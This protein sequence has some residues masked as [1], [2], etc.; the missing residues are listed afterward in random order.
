MAGK[1]F[2]LSVLFEVID[3]AS[4]PIQKI[5]RTLNTLIRP[6]TRVVTAFTGLA[7]K[8][9]KVMVAVGKN[10]ANV[11]RGLKKIGTRITDIGKSLALRVT[12]P[13]LALGGI[14]LNSAIKFESAFA[15]VRKTVNASEEELQKLK[16]GLLGLA[17]E[18]P[19]DTTEFFRIGEAAGQLGIQTKNIVAFSKVMAT[20]GATTNLSAEEAATALARFANITQLPQDQFDRIAS[21]I[22]EL[23][24]N[25]ATTEREIVD[26]AL[27]LASAADL[28]GLSEAETLS[29]AAALS[30]LGLQAQRG[31]TAF[32]KVFK[33]M[34]KEI[35]T[36]SKVLSGFAKVSGKTVSGFEESFRKNA[37]QAVLDFVEGLSRLEKEGENVNQVLEIL[38]FQD[39]RVADALLRAAG[40]GEGF[41]IA[42]ELGTKAFNENIAAAKELEKRTNT[43]AA[44]ITIAKN[45]AEQMSVSFGVI[46]KDALDELIKAIRPVIDWLKQLDK[47]TKVLI[48]IIGGLVAAISPLLIALGLLATFMGTTLAGAFT[49]FT[50]SLLTFTIGFTALAALAFVILKN[51]EPIKTLFLDIFDI[52]SEGIKG[53]FEPLKQ[54]F[55][56]L[57]GF[58]GEAVFDFNKLGREIAESFQP[59]SD[60]FSNLLTDI[61]ITFSDIEKAVKSG[62]EGLFDFLPDFIKKSIGVDITPNM[63]SVRNNAET[64]NRGSAN[65]SKADV[66]IKVISEKG[67][68][69]KVEKVVNRKGNISLNLPGLGFVG[70][71]T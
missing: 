49:A 35:G 18:I 13:L 60:F 58:I 30:S 14:A 46:L 25:M 10:I 63:Q 71:V 16:K 43:T 65:N 45:R 48:I 3:R 69:A 33:A 38:K 36:G 20:L 57:D 39:F 61:E 31:G 32:S 8:I 23:G 11:G 59:V 67:T 17:L 40:S 47:E 4:K 19:I 53:N 70:G 15:G 2:N 6:V 34:Q 62:T 24:N 55:T 12:A 56:D 7:K 50:A 54:F 52:L 68:A 22:V 9:R 42:I 28:A 29:F 64:F 21:T 27:E 51:W 44:R 41:R 66:T 1:Q 26:M 37:S 5:G